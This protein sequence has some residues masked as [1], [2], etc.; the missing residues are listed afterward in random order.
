MNRSS[1]AKSVGKIDRLLD[2]LADLAT[3]PDTSTEQFCSRSVQVTES[4]LEL[5]WAAVVAYAGDT[6]AVKAPIFVAGSELAAKQLRKLNQPFPKIARP[7]EDQ[8]PQ[9]S[10]LETLK[11]SPHVLSLIHI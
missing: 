10:W 5:Q 9:T 6:D 2:G 4:L 7:T 3:R 8:F 11:R 1:A